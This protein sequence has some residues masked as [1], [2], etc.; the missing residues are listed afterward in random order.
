MKENLK[1]IFMDGKEVE[2]FRRRKFLCNMFI[3]IDMN[4]QNFGGI[5][6]VY[7]GRVKGRLQ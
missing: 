2:I 5:L 7:N 3:I 4:E 6:W 1:R